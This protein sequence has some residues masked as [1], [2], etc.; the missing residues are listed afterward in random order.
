[1]S[2][3]EFTYLRRTDLHHTG[4]CFISGIDPS[5]NLFVEEIYE[6]GSWICLSILNSDGDMIHTSDEDYGRAAL[7]LP[8]GMAFPQEMRERGW[9]GQRLNFAGPRHRGLREPE[10][11]LDL[12]KPLSV[13]DKMA[14][15]AHSST[16]LPPERIL[17]LAESFVIGQAQISARVVF[18]CRRLR[19]AYALPQSA[20]DDEGVPYDYDTM[21]IQTGHLYDPTS[22]DEPPLESVLRGAAFGDRLRWPLDCAVIGDRLFVADGG[23]QDRQSAIHIWQVKLPRNN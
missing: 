14:L 11:L 23:A 5:D 6:N 1:M 10:K 12:V 9:I 17:G 2:L 8:A 7:T 18:V 21:V 16:S 4:D 19:V 20:L 15:S 22:D 13:A 3:P